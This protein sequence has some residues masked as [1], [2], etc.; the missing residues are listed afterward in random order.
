MPGRTTPLATGEYYHVY[1]RGV[2]DQPTFLQKGDYRQA[3]LAL[4]YYRFAQPP[5][6]LS[7]FKELSKEQRQYLVTDLKKKNE[8]LVDVVCFTLMPNH[9]HLLLHQKIDRGI[10]TFVSRFTNSYTR[11]FNTAH[12]R[13]GPLL[14]GV[15][16]AV[17]ILTTEQLLHVSRYIHLNPLVGYVVTETAFLNYPWSSL[18]QYIS[19]TTG[20]VNTE[21][22]LSHFASP[23]AYLQFVLD[24]ADYG[25]QLEY[26]KHLTLE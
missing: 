12:Q 13:S 3:L 26:I 21:P 24:Q 25:K 10:S 22:V 7:L 18:P 2:A 17:H 6:R 9:F 4:E 23:Q 15:F 20:F 14:N 1:N 19:N 8:T 5:V 16:K 11:F